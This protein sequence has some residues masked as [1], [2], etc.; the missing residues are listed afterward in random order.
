MTDENGFQP[1]PEPAPAPAQE[2][3]GG[4]ADLFNMYA[5]DKRREAE[6]I[7]VQ[8]GPKTFITIARAGGSNKKFMK[9]AEERSRAHRQALERGII[10][11]K[12]A[13]GIM[14]E[15]YADA[16]VLGWDGVL[17]PKTVVRDEDT[18]EITGS[19][20]PFT[21]A[22][23]IYLF[24]QLPELLLDIQDKASNP[25]NFRAGNTEAD[26]KN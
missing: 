2:D 23:V 10:D 21:R 22:N 14:R 24:E 8:F 25:A 17:D 6:G 13:E 7:K 11:P 3:A 18:G 1:G 4:Y 15:T 20:L 26:L 12:V 5:T 9:A 19:E 16:I